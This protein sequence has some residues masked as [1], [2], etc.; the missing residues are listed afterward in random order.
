MKPGDDDRTRQHDDAVHPH[1]GWS[2]GD[3]AQ[4]EPFPGEIEPP[5]GVESVPQNPSEQWG[6][7]AGSKGDDA[8]GAP[9][10]VPPPPTTKRSPSVDRGAGR[11]RPEDP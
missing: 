2:E 8:S 1:R 7:R 6:G 11:G 5:W 10:D 3:L 4:K 9:V